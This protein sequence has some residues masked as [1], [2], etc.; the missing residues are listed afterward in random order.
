MNCI[1]KFFR[2]EILVVILAMLLGAGCETLP[3]TN[4][5]SAPEGLQSIGSADTLQVGN[6]LI[7]NFTDT[8]TPIAPIEETIREDGMISLHLSQKIQAAGK[9]KGELEEQIKALYVPQFYVRLTVTIKTEDRFFSVGGEVR[10][11]NRQVYLG[12]MTV[13]KA[14]IAAGGF[15]EF[16]NKKNIEIIRSNRRKDKVNWYKAQEDPQK[17][18]LPIYPGDQIHVHRRVI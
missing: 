4:D 14:I 7:I 16:A 2:P 17:Y 9:K 18:D 13:L 1:H 5:V 8:P 12:E 10:T 11:P 6:K 3:T 15:T